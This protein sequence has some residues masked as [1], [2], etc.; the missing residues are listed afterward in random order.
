MTRSLDEAERDDHEPRDDERERNLPRVEPLL[1]H[2]GAERQ[3]RAEEREA[4]ERE[5]GRRREDADRAENGIARPARRYAAA[6]YASESRPDERPGQVAL[7]EREHA[8]A[9]REAPDDVEPEPVRLAPG[10]VDRDSGDDQREPDEDREH[11]AGSSHEPSEP[12]SATD[13]PERDR[14]REHE[15]RRPEAPQRDQRRTDR[16]RLEQ[17]RRRLVVADVGVEDPDRVLERADEDREEDDGERGEHAG[18]DG[19]AGL[20]EGRARGRAR[21]R[22]RAAL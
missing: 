10:A 18:G 1:D 6:T 20:L 17:Q 7:D 12:R 11:L 19:A 21:R 3:E 14:D 22:R 13:D 5:V 9:E 2:A 16:Q 4:V 8:A 15:Q